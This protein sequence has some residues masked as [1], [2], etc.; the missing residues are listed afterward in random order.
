MTFACEKGTDRVLVYAFDASDGTIA[1]AGGHDVTVGGGA[2]HFAIHPSGEFIYV[3]EESNPGSIWVFRF[4]EEV[5]R[6]HIIA[7]NCG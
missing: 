4:D 2:R 1:L 7:D 5:S 3:N 6:P